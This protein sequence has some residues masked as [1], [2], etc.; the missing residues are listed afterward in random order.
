MRLFKSKVETP[1]PDISDPVVVPRALYTPKLPWSIETGGP[2]RPS[3]ATLS[4][5]YLL[6][7]FGTPVFRVYAL[8]FV[9][10][11]ALWRT[12]FSIGSERCLIE[13]MGSGWLDVSHAFVVRYFGIEAAD[14]TLLLNNTIY[15]SVDQAVEACEDIYFL[16]ER[17]Y[18]KVMA[19]INLSTDLLHALFPNHPDTVE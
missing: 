7:G 18:T 6:G 1:E 10:R 5:D 15:D 8:P 4:I 12:S 13:E 19:A 17:E 9:D 16:M 3:A 2:H 11:D 14:K